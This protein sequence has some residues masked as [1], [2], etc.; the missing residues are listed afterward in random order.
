M[1]LL[2]AAF[3]LLLAA[4]AFSALHSPN[5]AAQNNDLVARGRYL[6]RDAG[7]CA[8]C[9]G[10]NLHGTYLG[11]LKPGMPVQYHSANI[12]GLPKLSV[13]AAV[14][15]LET[16]TLP[17]GKPAAPPMPAYRFNADDA[18]AIVAYLKTLK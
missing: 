15:F 12:A 5:V 13:A 6:V 14:R 18:R 3:V 10:E 11:F 16:G 2:P 4:I 1:R 7:K 8:D 9:H 17:N